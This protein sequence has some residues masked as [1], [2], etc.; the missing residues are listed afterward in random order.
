MEYYFGYKQIIHIYIHSF[1][2]YLL[3]TLYSPGL[4]LS[5][6]RELNKIDT[7]PALPELAF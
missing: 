1:N 3:G 7:F 6:R 4:V 5:A 2:Q